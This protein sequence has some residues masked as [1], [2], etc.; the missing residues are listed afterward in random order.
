VLDA[1]LRLTYALPSLRGGSGLRPT[2]YLDLF[3]L[4]NRCTPLIRDDVHYVALD[5]HGN[6]AFPNPGYG[7]PLEFQSPMSA[8]LAI[9]VDF[10]AEP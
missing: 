8:R 9:S 7:G 5:A 4:G 1:G 10:G 6:Q 3:Q 2:L